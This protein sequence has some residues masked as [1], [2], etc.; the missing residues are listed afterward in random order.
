M[1]SNSNQNFR[2]CRRLSVLDEMSEE[3]YVEENGNPNEKTDTIYKTSCRRK[4]TKQTNIRE[5]DILHT[6]KYSNP[7]SRSFESYW[8]NSEK[9]LPRQ[10]SDPLVRNQKHGFC[11]GTLSPF[12]MKK[13][14]KSRP[15]MIS[16]STIS[17]SLSHNDSESETE[18]VTTESDGDQSTTI[19]NSFT[20]SD[21]CL[22]DFQQEISK[23]S[24]STEGFSILNSE[25]YADSL[26]SHADQDIL[27]YFSVDQQ[28]SC[29]IYESIFSSFD[30]DN[31]SVDSSP[32]FIT[33]SLASTFTSPQCSFHSCSSSPQLSR[34]SPTSESQPLQSVAQ[35]KRPKIVKSDSVHEESCSVLALLDEDEGLFRRT[36]SCPSSKKRKQFF[37][38]QSEHRKSIGSAQLFALQNMNG[39]E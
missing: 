25:S 24:D 37:Q 27:Y 2:P 6:R 4:L 34:Q 7:Y 9:I 38:S 14:S 11:T 20:V 10:V 3:S 15:L 30:R 31:I 5:I 22:P 33:A 32:T 35:W 1:N 23:D 28:S 29:S 8:D 36:S 26:M 19:I 39:I 17:S 12:T 16:S 18:L 13:T 21:S